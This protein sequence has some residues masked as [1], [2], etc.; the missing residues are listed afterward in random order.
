[1]YIK[2]SSEKI[3]RITRSEKISY[4][5]SIKEEGP[6]KNCIDPLPLPLD[7]TDIKIKVSASV[8]LKSVD[9]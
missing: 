3:F 4:C 2:G 5:N 6:Y 8:K 1:M 9:L 7:E